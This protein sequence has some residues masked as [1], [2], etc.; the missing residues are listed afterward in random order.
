[1]QEELLGIDHEIDQLEPSDHN[2]IHEL[3][4]IETA[5]L[6]KGLLN[7]RHLMSDENKE[8]LHQVRDFILD[9][10]LMP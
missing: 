4:I 6:C 5:Y 8:L 9:K 10:C 7:L 1:M 2:R 3:S